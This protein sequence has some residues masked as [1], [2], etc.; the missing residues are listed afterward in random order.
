MAAPCPVCASPESELIYQLDRVPVTCASVFNSAAEARGVPTGTV[1]LVCCHQ[2]G[3]LYN[4][5]F[6]QAVADVGARYESDQ[7]ASAHFGAYAR[8]LALRWVEDYGLRRATVIE[9]G[10]GQGE[11]LGHL[12]DQ[13][14]G[15][16]V[17]FDPLANTTRPLRH[18]VKLVAS[19]F[20][21][22]GEDIDAAA[23]VCRHTLEHVA[24]VMPFMAAIHR[25]CARSADRVVLFE[26]PA[27]ER[28]L[29]EVA[30]WD[31]YYE[32][33]NYFTANTLRD[34]FERAGFD[35]QRLE[36]TYGEQYLVVEARATQQL[37][38][39]KSAVDPAGALAAARVFG[40]AARARVDRCRARLRAMATERGLPVIWQGAS[41]T[42]GL[43]TAI[44]EPTPALF[45][46]DASPSRHDQYLPGSGLG[47][48]APA[49][50]ATT[51]PR[52][53]I[54]MNPVYVSEVR[55]ELDA[56]T[57]HTQLTTINQLFAT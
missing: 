44:G 33:C 31:I 51:R 9:V 18:G 37:V 26:V 52:D 42:V 3:F 5:Q 25:W 21:A 41:K 55:A 40:G 39:G 35:V 46:V 54:L 8:E 16:A 56:L 11:F 45:A 32:H 43:L 28:I 57:P 4:N 13:G 34:V 53:V 17:G 15:A 48:R 24:D 22:G 50:L 23:L 2:C 10:C 12:L 7:G 47:I 38:G 14:V 49:V 6:D 1:R 36:L 29:S 20:E 30:F 19:R 27:T